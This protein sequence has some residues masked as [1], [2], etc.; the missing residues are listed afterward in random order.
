MYIVEQFY[1]CR[2]CELGCDTMALTLRTEAT[3]YDTRNDG[4]TSPVADIA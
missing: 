4:E 3:E 1:V 2:N